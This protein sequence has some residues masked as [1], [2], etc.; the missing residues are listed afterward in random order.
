MKLDKSYIHKYILKQNI[1][2]GDIN[3]GGYYDNSDIQTVIDN[4]LTA[5][6]YNSTTLNQILENWN[7]NPDTNE[8][9][10]QPEP[11]PEPRT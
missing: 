9:E 1:Y 11:E 7:P 8:P 3:N 4:W 2:M 10:P 6:S 5:P